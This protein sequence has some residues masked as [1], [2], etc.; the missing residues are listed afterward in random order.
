[1]LLTDQAKDGHNNKPAECPWERHLKP[2]FPSWGQAVNLSR[3]PSLTKDLQ[4]EPFF[5]GLV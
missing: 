2:H 5:V 1:M 3:W 4:T